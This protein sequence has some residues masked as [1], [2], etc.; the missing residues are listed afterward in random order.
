VGT[1]KSV[2]ARK[3]IRMIKVETIPRSSSTNSMTHKT[4]QVKKNEEEKTLAPAR[5]PQG[6]RTLMSSTPGPSGPGGRPWIGRIPGPWGYGLSFVG[7]QDHASCEGLPI[8]LIEGVMK[9]TL[10]PG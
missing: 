10:S 2:T 4:G 3:P 9:A 5:P 1:I 7:Q 8:D 6:A